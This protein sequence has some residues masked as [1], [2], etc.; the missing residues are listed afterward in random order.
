MWLGHNY[1]NSIML[2]RLHVHE[3][4]HGQRTDEVVPKELR[5]I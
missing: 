3:I 5:A 4:V 1:F 2:Y